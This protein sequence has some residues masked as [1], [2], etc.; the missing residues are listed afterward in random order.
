VVVLLQLET[1]WQISMDLCI[2]HTSMQIQ[3]EGVSTMIR[4]S[5]QKNRIQAMVR[6][7]ISW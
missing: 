3:A 6:P 2:F 1:S 5:N 7:S 4:K